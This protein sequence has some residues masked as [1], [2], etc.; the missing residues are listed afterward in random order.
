MKFNRILIA[1]ALTFLCSAAF[2]QAPNQIPVGAGGN[3]ERPAAG[4]RMGAQN[5]PAAA[6]TAAQPAM[7]DKKAISASCTKQADAQGLHGKARRA[8]REK[9]KRSH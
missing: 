4:S 6:P 5:K 7:A 9:C 2:A 1:G 8:F 3:V